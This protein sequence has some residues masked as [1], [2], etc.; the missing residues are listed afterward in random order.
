MYDL[1]LLT[2]LKP[3]RFIKHGE[4]DVLTL[5]KAGDG[6]F[7]DVMKTVGMAKNSSHVHQFKDT[8]L[9][10]AKDPDHK[11]HGLF[12]YYDDL[13][14]NTVLDKMVL[15]NLISRCIL[16]IED[17][18]EIIKPTTQ[19]ERNKVLLDILTERPY[20]TFHLFKD[21]L[22]E[23][24]PNNECVQMLVS[25]MQTTESREEDT[26]CHYGPEI[27]LH[28][29]KLQLQQNYTIFVHGVECK[30]D[31]ADYL[32]QEGVLN[33]EE[34]EEI[35]NSLLTQQESNRLLYHKLFRK[36]KDSYKHLLAALRH[37]QYEDVAS[38]IEET[39]FSDQEIQLYQIGM[40][41]LKD[42]LKEKDIPRIQDEVIPKHILE[43]FE[44]RLEQW[45]EDDQQFV[46]NMVKR[47]NQLDP[48]KQAELVCTQDV[49]DKDIALGGSCYMGSVDLV[50]WLISKNSDISYCDDA[51]DVNKC[52]NDDESPLLLASK[53]GHV[54]LMSLNVT[55]MGSCPTSS[56]PVCTSECLLDSE[57]AGNKLCCSGCCRSPILD[58]KPGTCP[59]DP[60]Q[61][62]C[63]GRTS[64]CE[65]DSQCD[66]KR[67]CCKFS[68]QTQAT[69]SFYALDNPCYDKFKLCSSS[70]EVVTLKNDVVCEFCICKNPDNNI[71]WPTTVSTVP[72]TIP[73]T[74]TT[75]GTRSPYITVNNIT[76]VTLRNPCQQKLAMCPT[77]CDKSNVSYHG[78]ICETCECKV[79]Q[80]ES[81]GKRDNPLGNVVLPGRKLKRENTRDSIQEFYNRK[82]K[83]CV[84]FFCPLFRCT[85]GK[86]FEIGP[87][88]CQ[89]K[90]II[91]ILKATSTL[92]P[93]TTQVETS[94]KIAHSGSKPDPTE[95]FCLPGPE[96]CHRDCLV[97]NIKVDDWH[98]FFC[99]CPQG[100]V[101]MAMLNPC[102]HKVRVC[103]SYCTIRHLE[104][105]ILGT[106][107]CDYCDC[108][109]TNKQK[110]LER[111]SRFLLQVDSKVTNIVL[112]PRTFIH[113]L[114][115]S[116]LTS[117]IAST[118][119]PTLPHYTKPHST[120]ASESQAT[121][122]EPVTTIYRSSPLPTSEEPVTTVN[123]SS[124][125]PS[126][127]VPVQTV[128]RSSPQPSRE[129]PVTTVNL[130]SPLP[131]QEVP[132]TTIQRP[133]PL[134]TSGSTLYPHT[135]NINKPTTHGGTISCFIC[136]STNCNDGELQLCSS[137]KKYCMNT[138]TAHTN[139]TKS[140]F[141]S[142]VSEDE[143]NKK[144]W[145]K[146]AD[147][148]M[149]LTLQNGE[150][151]ELAD[152]KE[153][154]F[155]CTENGCN[156]DLKIDDHIF[157]GKE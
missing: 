156:K 73:P 82:T 15:D 63:Y 52:T 34:K 127:E 58:N 105:I 6:K 53:N 71:L 45:K 51:A 43:Q 139:G 89:T 153:C 25:R 28:N 92:E 5:S 91:V 132:V 14:E 122:E 60:G 87:D 31:I 13:L 155:C 59:T 37:G 140:I 138:L 150:S 111:E 42:R 32:Y 134:P 8:L 56:F 12:R 38:K 85:A 16:M 88:G 118:S 27:S 49:R 129:V 102:N 21:V 109:T 47:L 124:S 79:L 74:I 93:S 61:Q 44:R 1:L 114:H 57:C 128:Y 46:K 136:N 113:H 137:G 152:A 17:R 144:W 125:L 76:Y 107:E 35:C 94:T 10:W 97:H 101:F 19:R 86:V 149:C 75:S 83:R 55:L 33:D 142:C 95:L 115:S 108:N 7:K 9:E 112:I 36:G 141:R 4:C 99:R 2:A 106:I 90:T 67:K 103:P 23:S 24:E 145:L 100:E 30:T 20:P 66:G 117:G 104:D 62:Q 68:S 40:K 98:C 110:G 130:S 81:F 72:T 96:Y 135:T 146:T 151:V 48:S 64:E 54:Q 119:I 157:I 121:S 41:K 50:K 11:L 147:D 84:P 126:T 133:S 18:E 65:K 78:R 26:Y 148:P 70:C 120:K 116:S 143:C 39:E 80:K 123:R 3:D 154:N 69:P 29:Y 22:K 77:F 131:S